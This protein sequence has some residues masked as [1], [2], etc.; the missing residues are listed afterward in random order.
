[1]LNPAL[2]ALEQ[3]AGM[4]FGDL[5]LAWAL[6][7]GDRRALARFERDYLARLPGQ[8]KSS[9]MPA[10]GELEQA[11][12]TRLLVVAEGEE[13]RIRT[14][15]GRGPLG[16]WVRMIATRAALD[17]RRSDARRAPLPDLADVPTDP[18]LDFLKQRYAQ[19]FSQALEAA[20]ASLPHRGATLLKLTFVDGL[21]A[22]AIGKMYGVSGRTVQRWVADVREEVLTRTSDALKSRLSLTGRELESLLGLM[23]SR[24]HVS[25]A[26]V[27][28]RADGGGQTGP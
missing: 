20:L 17:L 8:V 19:E 9:L 28:S 16:A 15:S 1:H 26:R 22:S 5:Y 11:V 6:G 7:S 21:S 25:L 3:L 2:P 12:L 18:E 14:Y 24:L 27:L 10:P 4:H 13:P 23:Q